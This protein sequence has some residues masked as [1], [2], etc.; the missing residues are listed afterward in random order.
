MLTRN[1]WSEFTLKDPSA[2]TAVLSYDWRT[3][4]LLTD[5]EVLEQALDRPATTGVLRQLQRLGLVRA[6][7]GVRTQG[8][9]MRL[10]ALSDVM[11]IQLALDLRDTSGARLSDC[12]AALL[13]DPELLEDAVEDWER[14]IGCAAHSMSAHASDED[15]R[16]LPAPGPALSDFVEA[17]VCAFVARASFEAVGRPAF[18]L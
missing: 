14:H 16:P 12:V 7:H 15:V 2:L 1:I 18:L 17:S 5:A 9:R 11:K 6:R 3:R 10:W 4:R 8:G 13:A